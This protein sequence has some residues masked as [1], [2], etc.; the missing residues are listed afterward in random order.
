MPSTFKCNDHIWFVLQH[1]GYT[2]TGVYPDDISTVRPLGAFT[3]DS[4]ISS[5][6]MATTGTY[7]AASA[8]ITGWGRTGEEH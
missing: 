7:V 5:I 2:P 3:F 4:S 1:P 8:T 6:T